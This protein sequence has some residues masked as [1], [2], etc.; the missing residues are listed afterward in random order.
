MTQ[1]RYATRSKGV[2]HYQNQRS[3]TRQRTA[4]N[5]YIRGSPR[6]KD[7]CCVQRPARK[8]KPSCLEPLLGPEVRAPTSDWLV[9]YASSLLYSPCTIWFA[10]V[11]TV[12]A[13]LGMHILRCVCS[14]CI[15][16][17]CDAAPAKIPI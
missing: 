12:C 17:L 13:G 3:Q 1:D 6:R 16:Y 14:L 10:R 2:F 7:P 4:S 9:V 8:Q 15:S 5:M 11:C